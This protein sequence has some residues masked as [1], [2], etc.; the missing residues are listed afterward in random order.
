MKKYAFLIFLV[1]ITASVFSQQ[2]ELTL[3][4][5]VL[6]RFST[7]GPER[8]ADLQWVKNTRW[9]PGNLKTAIKS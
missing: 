9:S 3:E 5:A 2:K 6:K 7:L 8:L 4:N 1:S